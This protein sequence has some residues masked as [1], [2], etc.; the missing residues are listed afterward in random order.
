M[1]K[2]PSMLASAALL[3]SVGLLQLVLSQATGEGL[4]SHLSTLARQ[5]LGARFDHSQRESRS[6]P[7]SAAV[8]AENSRLYELLSLGKR[9]DGVTAVALVSRRDPDSWWARMTVEFASP[10]RPQTTAM[11]LTPGGVIGS[12]DPQSIVE[13]EPDVYSARV[14][15]LT[16]PTAQLSVLAGERELP[17][18]LE[19]RGSSQFKLRAVTSETAPQDGG[20]VKTAGLGEVFARG[21]VVGQLNPKSGGATATPLA[22]TPS[23][24]L[25]WWR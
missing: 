2:K 9:L 3:L 18:L 12:L 6:Y 1:N 21:L 25:L 22:H 14:E 16:A 17:F 13:L 5:L 19:G 11:V 7:I 24:V 23:E 4:S 10:Q 20:T 8:K 15:L